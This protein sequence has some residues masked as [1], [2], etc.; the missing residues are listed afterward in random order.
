M[1]FCVRRQDDN[2]HVFT[3]PHEGVWYDDISEAFAIKRALEQRLHKQ[4]YWI[5]DEQG[6]VITLSKD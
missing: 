5:E 1:R 4:D 2:G 3:V 6:R